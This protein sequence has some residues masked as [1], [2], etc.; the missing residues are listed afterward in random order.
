VLTDGGNGRRTLIFCDLND[1]LT[2]TQ[3][4]GRTF[5][6]S[7]SFVIY[8]EWA[9]SHRIRRS[10]TVVASSDARPRAAGPGYTKRPTATDAYWPPRS[11]RRNPNPTLSLGG[12]Q[13]V[14]RRRRRRVWLCRHCQPR[15]GGPGRRHRQPGCDC[16]GRWWQGHITAGPGETLRFEGS[17]LASGGRC[18][19]GPDRLTSQG[20][21]LFYTP[22]L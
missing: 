12:H 13:P 8:P 17:W 20:Q 21:G 2:A 9:E 7:E 19:G 16:H 6:V 10:V 18:P 11:T 4:R 5:A 3:R 15:C 22:W 14:V 1:S